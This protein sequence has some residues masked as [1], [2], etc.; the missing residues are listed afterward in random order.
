VILSAITENGN[1]LEL[2]GLDGR[3]VA[4]SEFE[5]RIN[6][7]RFLYRWTANIPRW[8]IP[9]DAGKPDWLSLNASRETMVATLNGERLCFGGEESTACYHPDFGIY[10]NKPAISR[11]KPDTWSDD[12]DEFDY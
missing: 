7:A 5:W 9:V 10:A 6:A 2:T 1:E 8:M 12:D 4:A 11:N 3:Q